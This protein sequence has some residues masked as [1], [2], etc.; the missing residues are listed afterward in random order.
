M[1]LLKK[2]KK[3]EIRMDRTPEGMH[4]GMTLWRGNKKDT[5]CKPSKEASEESKPAKTLLLDF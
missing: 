3:E 1:S 2:K 4:R 5:I